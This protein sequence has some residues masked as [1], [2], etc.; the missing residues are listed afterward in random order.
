MNFG[1]LTALATALAIVIPAASEAA[2]APSWDGTW[3]GLLNNTEP[4]SVTIA[5]GRVVSYEIRGGQ[6]FGIRYS[7][8]TLNSVAFGDPR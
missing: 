5:D 6:P 4:V 3:T 8:V 7:K 1:R 2:S